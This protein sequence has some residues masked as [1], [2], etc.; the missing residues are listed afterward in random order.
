MYHTLTEAGRCTGGHVAVGWCDQLAECCT[1]PFSPGLISCTMEAACTSFIV[2][3]A[4]DFDRVVLCD[5]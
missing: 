4:A 2:H 3:R 1:V 5:F